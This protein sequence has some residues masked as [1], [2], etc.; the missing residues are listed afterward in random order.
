MT[1]INFINR[2]PQLTLISGLT[3]RLTEVSQEA[4]ERGKMSH[5][6]LKLEKY[7]VF[8]VLTYQRIEQLQDHNEEHL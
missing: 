7:F 1:K 2:L 8:A 5:L 4:K 6:Y 3:K